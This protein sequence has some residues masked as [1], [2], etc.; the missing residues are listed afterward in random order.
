[1]DEQE[2]IGRRYSR[3]KV[4]PGTRGG[5]ECISSE[6][7]H[8][9][10][11]APARYKAWATTY[12]EG[13]GVPASALIAKAEADGLL[14]LGSHLQDHVALRAGT[15]HDDVIMLAARIFRLARLVEVFQ[16]RPELFRPG[17][18]HQHIFELGRLT[19]L[20]Q[21]YVID[22]TAATKRVERARRENTKF[23]DAERS[24]WN[25]LRTREFHTHSKRRAAE[26]IVSRL[27]LPPSAIESVRKALK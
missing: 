20:A 26:L 19:M 3:R 8:V 17:A 16:S 27:N 2:E 1:M 5:L 9:F 10:S 24:M 22:D 15:S 7:H 18:G 4:V 23:T 6:T 12:L 13:A 21:V 25:E 11:G 14:D